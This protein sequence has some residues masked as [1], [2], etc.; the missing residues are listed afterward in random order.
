[1]ELY[2]LQSVC[3]YILSIC[4][5]IYLYNHN[6]SKRPITRGLK[7]V[8]SYPL[9][10]HLPAYIRNRHRFLDWTTE[11]LAEHPTQTVTYRRPGVVQGVITANPINVEYM[12]KTNFENYPKGDLFTSLLED[13]LGRGIFNSDGELW[14][15]QRKTAVYEFNTKS[16]RNFILDSILQ[17]IHERLLPF[18]WKATKNGEIINLQDVLEQFAFNN[19]CKIAF[20][21]DPMCLGGEDEGRLPSQFAQAFEDAANLSAGRFRYS[22]PFLW[23]IKKMLNIGSERR[24]RESITIIHDFAT[25]I[26]KT[27]KKESSHGRDD[28]LSRF[29]ASDD[30]SIEFLRDIIISFILAG[31][32]TTSSALA[33]FFWILSSRPDVEQKILE[34]LKLVTIQNGNSNFSFDDLQKMHYLHASIS[35]ALRLYP[36]VAYD[37]K[38][39]HHDDVMPDGTF[40]GKGWLVSYH[41]YAM[42]R[43]ESIWGPNCRDFTPERWLENGVFKPE[44]P[45]RFPAFNGGPRVCL[46]REMA[47][48]QMK[49][50]VACVLER[51]EIDVVE[52]DSCPEQMLSLTLRI[53]GGLLVRVKER[54]MDEIH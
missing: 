28:L 7:G 14:K 39:C 17:E 27:R 24:L 51:F 35:E 21:E 18:L 34:E 45:F 10:G 22:I 8:R 1:M 13:F 32:D 30:N 4:F 41:A 15:V 46:G 42:G 12:L 2:F 23:K 16:L 48:L 43:M 26:I 19:V 25:K 38:E 29:M 3:L 49:L 47:Y 50:I 44:S 37:T 36:P 53:K 9:V 52:K 40:V 33:W 11:I 54:C 31:R 20:N 6:R 5:L